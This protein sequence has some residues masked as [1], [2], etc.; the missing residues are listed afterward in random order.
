MS[1]KAVIFD[2]YNTLFDNHT[3]YW[4]RTFEEICQKQNL[5]I[6]PEEL[7]THW[8]AI[9]VSFRTNRLNLANPDA[10]PP[11]KTYETAWREAF[12]TTFENLSIN[13][14]TEQAAKLS[15]E[16]LGARPPYPDTFQT[17]EAVQKQRKVAFLTNAD[18]AS[19][20]KLFDSYNIASNMLFTSEKLQTY[21]PNPYVFHEVIRSLGLVAEETVY[22]GD[23]L[24][25]DIHGAKS[26]GLTA[27]WIN[28]N[29]LQADPTLLQADCEITKLNEL[30]DILDYIDEV[31]R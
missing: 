24:V 9:E 12:E 11:F 31:K 14:N 22:V 1:I 6:D 27:V 13:G 3:I 2:I 7:W 17:L 25:E 26:A 21:K 20:N 15:I 28:R 16:S 5:K 18:N 23:T 4:H 30:V 19:V 29:E 8:K 10:S